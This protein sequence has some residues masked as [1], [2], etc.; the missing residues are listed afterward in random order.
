MRLYRFFIFLFILVSF[1]T[2][3]FGGED[4][5]FSR[6]ILADIFGFL[7]LFIYIFFGNSFRTISRLQSSWILIASFSFGIIWS[8]F[9]IKSLFEIIILIFLVLL[10]ITMVTYFNS[11]D[12]LQFLV[13]AF[14]W[15][16]LAG[17][18][19][20]LYDSLIA[21]SGGLPRIFPARARGEALSGFRNAGQA[22]AYMYL[23]CLL[24]FSLYSSKMY[25]IF[26]RNT[27]LLIATSLVISFLFFITT[28]KVAAYIGF[29]VS[30]F[31]YFIFKRNLKVLLSASSLIFV[32][33]IIVINLETISPLLYNR[34]F[35]KVRTRVL[36]PAEGKKNNAGENFIRANFNGALE[37]FSDNPLT[38]SG[39]GGFYGRY[40]KHEVH[41]T[42]LKIIGET[43]ILGIIGYCLFMFYFI[44]IFYISGI[45]N[46][47][48]PYEDILREMAPL[49][50]GCL[51]SW[52]YTY[53]LRK[54]EF[55]IFYAIIIIINE[56]RLKW[57]SEQLSKINA[58]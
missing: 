45:K 36:E 40:D 58:T 14:A 8:Y 46:P 2:R 23:S 5:L 1:I 38:A 15:A 48:N 31:S 27:Q 4:G 3:T 54:R 50:L 39:I 11:K 49:I 18:L 17:A 24:L 37:A 51:V 34:L 13:R 26:T 12:R 22:G 43:G 32:I 44:K 29:V 30:F 57:N 28:G 19:I 33:G 52:T 16:S 41:S 35:Q 7:A 47:N 25:K 56:L 21:G 9:P 10:Q 53:H 55:W 42:Y 20:G 6:I